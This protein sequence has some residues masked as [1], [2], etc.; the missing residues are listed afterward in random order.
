MQL[1]R[2]SG[3]GLHSSFVTPGMISI[4]DFTA[5]VRP[6][7]VKVEIIDFK[8]KY[9][10]ASVSVFCT[11]NCLLG[12]CDR[13]KDR[14]WLECPLSIKENLQRVPG[15]PRSS[16]HEIQDSLVCKDAACLKYH[17]LKKSRR[18]TA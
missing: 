1:P 5:R 8:K 14:Q 11:L 16:N 18:S 12:V 9:L 13:H 3:G 6:A 2:H 7:D 10:G 15:F 4:D 17:E